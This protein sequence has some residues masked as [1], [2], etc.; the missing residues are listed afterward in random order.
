[1]RLQLWEAVQSS[2]KINSAAT[3]LT[4]TRCCTDDKHFAI[5]KIRLGDLTSRV[6]FTA[7]YWQQGLQ[8]SSR[9]KEE[10]KKAT[11]RLQM[12][13][14]AP[15]Y[16]I[17][18]SLFPPFFFF[19]SCKSKT[20]LSTAMGAFLCLYVCCCKQGHLVA[21]IKCRRISRQP[22]K[23]EPLGRQAAEWKWRQSVK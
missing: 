4:D 18:E 7:E 15:V 1:M 12:N 2:D 9:K 14:V 23:I 5:C 13:F 19:Y 10:R 20:L 11:S 16:F 6:A 21:T 8:K 17:F 22:P 3:K